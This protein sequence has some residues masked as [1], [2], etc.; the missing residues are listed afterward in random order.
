M[1]DQDPVDRPLRRCSTTDKT[2]SA[3][4]GLP[5][6]GTP[7]ETSRLRVPIRTRVADQ[8]TDVCRT[9]AD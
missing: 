3:N 6:S 7:P 5:E 2:T 8:L 9:S 4:P 1:P